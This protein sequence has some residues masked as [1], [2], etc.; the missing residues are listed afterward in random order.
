[1][2]TIVA[3]AAIPQRISPEGVTSPISYGSNIEG[4][5]GYLHARHYLPFVRTKE[6]MS[7]VFNISI[8]EGSLHYLLN[9]FADRPILF[10]QTIKQRICS[11]KV[12]GSD[13][14][15]AKVNG[16]KHQS[17]TWQTPKPTYIAHCDTRGKAAIKAH[18]AQGFLGATLVRDGWR[19]QTG[20]TAEHH[21]TCLPH[22]IR[23]L[24]YLY[25]FKSI[26][27]HVGSFL[28][29]YNCLVHTFRNGAMHCNHSV[30]IS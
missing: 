25:Q 28:S 7:D 5:I 30:L 19:T 14:T 26:M 15:G 29:K 11:S 9:R 16:N 23:D 20:T 21:R 2:A 12:I 1:M 4:L 6:M 13:E 27:S 3:V 24:S 10:Y 17:W 8:S 18:S 22:L